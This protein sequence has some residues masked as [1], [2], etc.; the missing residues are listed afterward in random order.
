LIFGNAGYEYYR[1]NRLHNLCGPAV[2]IYGYKYYYIFDNRLD[3]IF[4]Y[5]CKYILCI[6]CMIALC[7]AGY[8]K[9]I[10]LF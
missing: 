2:N 3:E 4:L 6:L 1:H 5:I 8:S 9:L 10:N 7:K